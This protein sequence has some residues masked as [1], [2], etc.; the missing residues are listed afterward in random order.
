MLKNILILFIK[1]K[2]TEIT[3]KVE[4]VKSASNDNAAQ[5]T[6]KEIAAIAEAIK[7]TS[8][9]AIAVPEIVAIAS[10]AETVIKLVIAE[11]ET[12]KAPPIEES[13]T[14]SES[15]QKIIT[16][17]YHN[18]FS[19]V[20]LINLTADLI[21]KPTDKEI[22]KDNSHIIPYNDLFVPPTPTPP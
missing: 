14:Y 10:A 17:L 15:M 9:I 19:Q 12:L 1:G 18:L 22:L 16:Q 21:D 3:E 13:K 5:T 4:E 7:D 8:K 2:L 20:Y 11:F 6:A